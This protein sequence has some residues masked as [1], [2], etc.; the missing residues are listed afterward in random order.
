MTAHAGTNPDIPWLLPAIRRLA[1]WWHGVWTMA[2]NGQPSARTAGNADALARFQAVMLPHLD[3]AH[4]LARYLCRDADTAEDIVQEAFLRAFRGFAD[5][6]GGSARAWL[7]TIVRNC[8]RS[9]WQA[10]QRSVR[11]EPLDAGE[12]E[13]ERTDLPHEEASPETALLQQAEASEIRAVLDRLPEAFREVLVLREMEELSYREI[14]ETIA[15]PM[16]TVMSRLARARTL[17]AAAWKNRQATP[18]GEA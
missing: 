13:E 8:H 4:N 9:W 1:A 2:A 17:F 16:G 11:T 7:L 14:A 5:Y 3:A 12:G 6:R 10:R 15:A 18:G